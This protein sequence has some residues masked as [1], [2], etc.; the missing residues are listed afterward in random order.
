M[1]AEK[2][3]HLQASAFIASPWFLFGIGL[4]TAWPRC[5]DEELLISDKIFC[6]KERID[7]K[8][9]SLLCGLCVIEGGTI[10]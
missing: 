9:K 2:S 7:R 6:H 4:V 5:S 8:R 10:H 1:A 3:P